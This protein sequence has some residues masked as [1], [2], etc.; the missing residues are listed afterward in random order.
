MRGGLIAQRSLTIIAV[1]V[2]VS[3]VAGGRK[4]PLGIIGKIVAASKNDADLRRLLRFALQ[5]QA[6][7]IVKDMAV[8]RCLRRPIPLSQGVEIRLKPN[9]QAIFAGLQTCKSVWTCAV[10]ASRISESRAHEIATMIE[11]AK[12]W[13]ETVGMV[14][15]TLQHSERQPLL[16][17]LTALKEARRWMLRHRQ[18]KALKKGLNIVGSATSTEITWSAKNGFH[19]HF[20][21]VLFFDAPMNPFDK[22]YLEGQLNN[23]WHKALLAHS[24]NGL[25]GIQVK[26]TWG[27]GDVS[28][29][30]TK[31]G[32]GIGEWGLDRELT[33]HYAK[34]AEGQ[35]Y[36]MQG[37]LLSRLLADNLEHERVWKEYALTT[38]GMNAIV[39]SQGLR[40]RYGLDEMSDDDLIELDEKLAAPLY[41]IPLP[42]WKKIII[43]DELGEL[44]A[45]ILITAEF[46]GVGGL[47]S[48]LRDYGIL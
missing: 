19:P 15:Y 5:A 36:T 41:T 39:F 38:K 21:E 42:Y 10:C 31:L 18:Y 46:G 33:K 45:K 22:G 14:T 13:G 43:K 25:T 27:N 44:R 26:A 17:T 12:A 20:H 48:L 8:A 32:S 4:P 9:G 23:L 28:G 1:A 37:L 24:A 35:S 34:V 11:Q 2:M 29:Y 47:E 7:A 6:R 40:K 16:Q 3:R 30:I